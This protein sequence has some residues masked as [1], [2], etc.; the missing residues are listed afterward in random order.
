MDRIHRL[1]QTRKVNVIRFVMKDS[2]EERIVALQEAK[3]LQA[4]SA[5]EKLKPEE[6]RKARMSDLKGLLLLKD[7]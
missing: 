7:E 1:D 2:I 5:L 3:S 4:K 6:K